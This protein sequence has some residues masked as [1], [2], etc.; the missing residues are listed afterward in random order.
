MHPNVKIY[1]KMAVFCVVAP[2]SLVEVYQRFRGP[3]CLHH[4]G[5]HR[6]KTAIFVLTAVRTSNP[7]L[8]IYLFLSLMTLLII[9]V[10]ERINVNDDLGRMWWLNDDSAFS[11]I[12][13]YV[14]LP[15]QIY[16]MGD[17][18]I[19]RPLPAQENTELCTCFEREWHNSWRLFNEK[20]QLQ[21]LHTVE[22]NEKTIM[23]G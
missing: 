9:A 10:N 15:V 19:S 14:F 13:I 11:A 16:C 6:Q 2:Y 12:T 20:F 4:R 5:D 1:L 7:T 8:K 3:C 23:N 17:Q 22:W 18:P 21:R